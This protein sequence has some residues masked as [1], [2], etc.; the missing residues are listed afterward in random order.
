MITDLHKYSHLHLPVTR[1]AVQEIIN[2][3]ARGNKAKPVL[4]LELIYKFEGSCI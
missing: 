3:G 1:V 2:H 4:S